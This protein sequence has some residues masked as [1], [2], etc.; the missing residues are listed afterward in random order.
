MASPLHQKSAVGGTCWRIYSDNVLRVSQSI[1]LNSCATIILYG[2]SIW[3]LHEA[4]KITHVRNFIIKLLR[5]HAK[6]IQSHEN[7][8]V[9]HIGQGK[10]QRKI[11]FGSDQFYG[12]LRDQAGIFRNKR[13]LNNVRHTIVTECGLIEVSCW[14]HCTDSA[15]GQGGPQ[16]YT[17]PKFVV[18]FFSWQNSSFLTKDNTL[19]PRCGILK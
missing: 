11:L 10:A 1:T 12:R 4:F 17:I 7:G 18:F 5:I 16:K 2:C 8:N 15:V 14:P 9:H 6:A 13:K 3:D 19:D